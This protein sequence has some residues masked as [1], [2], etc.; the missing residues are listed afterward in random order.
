MSICAVKFE[1]ENFDHLCLE[2]IKS[3]CIVKHIY[4]VIWH[5][6]LFVQKSMT[7]DGWMGGWVDGW[8]GGWLDGWLAGWMDGG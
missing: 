1:V 6:L 7:L 4:T 2:L 8:M 5:A 3:I